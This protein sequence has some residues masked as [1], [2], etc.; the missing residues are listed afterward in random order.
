GNWSGSTIHYVPTYDSAHPE[1]S[2]WDALPA[3]TA[4]PSTAWAD[5]PHVNDVVTISDPASSYLSSHADYAGWKGDICKY[6]SDTGAGPANYRMPTGEEFSIDSS[7]PIYGTTGAWN[8]ISNSTNAAGTTLIDR[9]RTNAG[10]AAF[11]VSGYRQYQSGSSTRQ[12]MSGEYW[13]GSIYNYRNGVYG[14]AHALQFFNNSVA[15]TYTN[16]NTCAVSVR[17]IKIDD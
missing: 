2:T 12:G 1:N 17:C 9:G 6:L 7:W 4:F 13:S 5:L 16:L 3:A 11:P 10:G 8:E 15:P 14:S